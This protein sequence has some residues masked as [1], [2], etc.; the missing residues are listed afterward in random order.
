MGQ[1]TE[2]VRKLRKNQTLAEQRLWKELRGKKLNGYK[3]L[4]QQ[5]IIYETIPK[6]RF[7]VADFYCHEKQLVV[8][9]DGKIHNSQKEY[10]E[11]R[12]RILAGL[13]LRVIRFRNDE[14]GDMERVLAQIS[15]LL[16]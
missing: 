6:R 16:E 11:N 1:I 5:P 15:D 12:D 2:L 14:L 10:D 13:G 4:R 3:F 9:L 8:E 7:F